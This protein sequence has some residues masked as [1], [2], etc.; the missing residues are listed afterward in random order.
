MND[1]T[2][3]SPT[4]FVFGRDTE[5]KAGELC[6]ENGATRV[7]LVYGG[8]S[9]RR[10][11]LLR[12]VEASLEDAGL[13]WTALGGVQPN[14][15]VSLV[16]RGAALVREKGADFILAVG[17]GSVIDTAKGIGVA[18]LY[19]G[20]VWDFFLRTKNP[21]NMLPVGAVPT[22]AAA[23]S[24]GSPNCVLT[25][26]ELK[27]K[28]GCIS[29][30]MRPRFAILNP[31]LTYTLPAYQTACGVTDIMMHTHE[32]Y[33]TPTPDNQ[34][35][36]EFCEGLLRTMIRF[37]PLALERPEDYNVRAQIMWCGMVSHNNTVGVGRVQDG[38]C[39]RIQS[40]IGGLYDSAHGAGLAA[41]CP[42]WML[43]VYKNH[44]PRFIRYATKVWGVDY[45]SCHPEN[46][47]LEG[48]L[49]LKNFFRSLGMPVTMEELGVRE[50]DVE[51][52]CRMETG[53]LQHLG[54]EDIREIYRLMRA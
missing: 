33:F 38:A 47:A 29:D 48:I 12:R 7:L 27:V 41:V 37:G 22:L 25:N 1:F 18:A 52:L 46:T 15:R 30:C 42:A 31:E 21:E 13:E 49:R 5:A 39:H 20:D 54:P 6:R 2:F 11:G 28:S 35:T 50:E 3:Y 10:S 9:A 44:L 4:K 51:T 19:G 14:P 8:S 32:R 40:R 53:N 26:D 24:E 45:D 36:D 16:R 17:G 23:G 43:Y 34:L